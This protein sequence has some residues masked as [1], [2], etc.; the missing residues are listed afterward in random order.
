MP[1]GDRAEED[2]PNIDRPIKLEKGEYT[3]INLDASTSHWVV[4]VIDIII[5]MYHVHMIVFGRQIEKI[6]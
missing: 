3:I 2:S 5:I 6:Q 1:H 4:K